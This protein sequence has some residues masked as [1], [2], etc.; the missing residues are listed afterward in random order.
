MSQI[1]QNVTLIAISTK[2]YS[3]KRSFMEAIYG[4]S[5]LASI[6]PITAFL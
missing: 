5:E 2:K 6:K 3:G 4:I 1:V